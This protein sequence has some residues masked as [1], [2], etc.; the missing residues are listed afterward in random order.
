MGQI[1]LQIPT[2]GQPNA[3]EDPKI[4]SDFTTIQNVIN[5]NIDHGNLAT[6]V[7][8]EL[9]TTGTT[10]K[11]AWGGPIAANVA[12]D[13]TASRSKVAGATQAHGLGLTP[14]WAIVI[15]AAPVAIVEAGGPVTPACGI[16]TLDGTNITWN[17][18]V[19]GTSVNG[20][21]IYWMAIG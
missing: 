7:V 4:A 8:L 16:T 21:S 13:G 17:A 14:V 3:T 18:T 12:L 19:N 1:A 6:G 9:A 10:R 20:F 15:A 11:V 5:G 2:V